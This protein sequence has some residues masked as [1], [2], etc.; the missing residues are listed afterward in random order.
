MVGKNN[1]RVIYT[2][3]SDDLETKLHYMGSYIP[4]FTTD[5]S[6]TVN[7]YPAPHSFTIVSLA[8]SVI[9]LYQKPRNCFFRAKRHINLTNAEHVMHAIT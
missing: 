8:M 6:L 7:I 4:N 3:T 2:C 5:F 1:V 9:L